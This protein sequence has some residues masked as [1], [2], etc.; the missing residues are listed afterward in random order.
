ML[1]SNRF[2]EEENADPLGLAQHA[3]QLLA[4]QRCGVG[5]I[6]MRAAGV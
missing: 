4:D 3:L 1:A 6:G 5:A 2:D